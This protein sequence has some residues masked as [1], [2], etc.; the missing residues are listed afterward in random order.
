MRH[1][2]LKLFVLWQMTFPGVPCIYY[3]DETGVMEGEKDPE[4]RAAYPWGR[5]NEEIREYF[6]TMIALRNQYDVLR[7]G[8][9]EALHADG[10]AYAYVR[11]IAGGRDRFGQEK[12]D[13]IAVILLN[14][15]VEKDASFDLDLSAWCAGT[16]AGT[17]AGTLLDP[18]DHYK[19]T[20]FRENRLNIS[21]K[22]LQGRLLLRNRWDTNFRIF[23]PGTSVPHIIAARSRLGVLLQLGGSFCK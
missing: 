14:R 21:L 3:G 4:N 23:P 18:L 10:G 8:N 17:R 7:S 9:W 19:E 2:R 20:A 12:E 16:K 6:Q 5:E 22:P 13:N 11:S 1:A 15:D